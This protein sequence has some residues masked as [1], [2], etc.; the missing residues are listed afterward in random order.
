[1]NFLWK[2]VGS[3]PSGHE[4]NCKYNKIA[5]ISLLATYFTLWDKNWAPLKDLFDDLV[6]ARATQNMML[7]SLF[8]VKLDF[9]VFWT[10]GRHHTSSM[11]AGMFVLCCFFYTGVR[12]QSTH[13]LGGIPERDT[14]EPPSPKWWLVNGWNFLFGLGGWTTPLNRNSSELRCTK[15]PPLLTSAVSELML[16]DSVCLPV[17]SL[18]KGYP[19]ESDRMAAE[20]NH[21]CGCCI[22]HIWSMPHVP[23]G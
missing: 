2:P 23:R 16:S 13:P 4:R 15:T 3:S 19:E 5:F 9:R 7:T 21:F 11:E 20:E 10:L 8:Q 18:H 17:S 12:G 22:T 14:L 6:H 1:M